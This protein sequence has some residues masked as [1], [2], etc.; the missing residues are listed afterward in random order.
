MREYDDA[1][2]D[3]W[4][5]RA[6]LVAE[7]TRCLADLG[8]GEAEQAPKQLLPMVGGGFFLT[9]AGVVPRL[10]L[11]VAKWASY[12][13][14]A[15][16]AASRST[17]TIL[18]SAA[19]RGDPLARIHG[20]RAT[21]ARTAATAVAVAR[22]ARPDTVLRRIGLLGFGPTN[23]SVLDT[24]L[25]TLD[26]V[27]EVRIVVRT[28]RTAQLVRRQSTRR[29]PTVSVGTDPA[30]L[31]G[32]DLAVSATGATAAVA[33]LDLI[34]P[35]GVVVCLDGAHIWRHGG[36][37]ELLDDRVVAGRVPSVARMFC[38]VEPPAGRLLLDVAGSAVADA[39][40]A[41][42]LLRT[43]DPGRLTPRGADP[44]PDAASP[45]RLS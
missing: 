10:G 27:E 23:R 39:A 14:T 18:V 16:G 22:A 7:V 9:L 42:L 21:E 32:V 37:A 24:V 36:A 34:A 28:E 12:R 31:A 6:A 40:L 44:Q 3:R 29:G 30:A 41:S 15:D 1:H 45:G 17:A 8:R 20:M 13:P 4:V 43:A 2:V 26:T 25:A 11:A 35:D 38:G 33:D 19:D 5:D